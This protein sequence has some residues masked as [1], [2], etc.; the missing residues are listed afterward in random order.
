M[1]IQGRKVVLME[2]KTINDLLELISLSIEGKKV[3]LGKTTDETFTLLKIL[4]ES[5]DEIE[6][7]T[8]HSTDIENSYCKLIYLGE[9]KPLIINNT[10]EHPDTKDSPLNEAF[11]VGSYLGVPVFYKDGKMF[12]TIC[13]V[14]KDVGTFTEKE[15]AIL[16]KFSNLF[17]HVLELE[18]YANIDSLT[19]LYNR[20]YLYENFQNIES[21]KAVIL[22]DLDNFK[23]VNDTYGHQIGDLVLREVSNRIQNQVGNNGVLARLGGDEFVIIVTEGTKESLKTMAKAIILSLTDWSDFS[24]E[25]TTSVSV[26][27]TQIDDD[28]PS[29]IQRAIKEADKAM[30]EA[31]R[32]GGSTYI[33][34]ESVG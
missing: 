29:S 13:V 10:K 12:G 20:H 4:D 15:S 30:Y 34:S 28:L 23:N 9:Q 6:E 24:V 25:V 19:Y 3:F 8:N 21:E 5:G 26:G 33:F 31:K 32:K 18:K 11:N 27:I 1:K 16:Q 2:Q 17:S 14:G 22:L 7:L